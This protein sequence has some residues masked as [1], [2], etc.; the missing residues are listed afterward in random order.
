MDVGQLWVGFLDF[1]AKWDDEERVVSIRQSAVLTKSEKEWSSP[2]P[3]IA[4]EDPFELS[5]NLGAGLSEE[6]ESSTYFLTSHL[7]MRVFY[8]F[9]L[10]CIA[11]SRKLLLRPGTTTRL[12]RT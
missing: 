1:Y 11:I 12:L 10:Q 4:I 5:R 6:S 3:C 8:S 2:F 9:A 7:T